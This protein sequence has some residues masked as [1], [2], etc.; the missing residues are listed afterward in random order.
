[1]N[2]YHIGDVPHSFWLEL[3]D[4]FLFIFFSNS[5]SICSMFFLKFVTGYLTFNRTYFLIWF[6]WECKTFKTKWILQYAFGKSIIVMSNPSL[7][8][9]GRTLYDGMIANNK[10]PKSDW[11]KKQSNLK[12]TLVPLQKQFPHRALVTS[13]DLMCLSAIFQFPFI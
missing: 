8:R 7:G 5:C 12:A 3:S 10:I 9:Q 1:M 13:S 2:W 6:K 4:L 11:F